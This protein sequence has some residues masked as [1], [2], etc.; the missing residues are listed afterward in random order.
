M[1]SQANVLQLSRPIRRRL[2][3]LSLKTR[4]KVVFRRCQIVLRL[5]NGERPAVIAT[6]LGCAL[7]TVYRTRQAFL[8]AGEASLPPRKVPGGH[9]E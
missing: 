7:S 1:V 2:Y 5:A 4:H 9:G 6:A 3:R 8:R